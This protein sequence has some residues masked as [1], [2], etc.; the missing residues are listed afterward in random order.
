VVVDQQDK[1][2][3]VI[4]LSD[5]LGFLALRPLDDDPRCEHVKEIENV[6]GA[7]ELDSNNNDDE[8]DI[9]VEN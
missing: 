8:Q 9:A 3:G 7:F 4:S 6:I 2:Q 1:V 5:I